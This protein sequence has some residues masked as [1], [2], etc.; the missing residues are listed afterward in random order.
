MAI[1]RHSDTEAQLRWLLLHP[2]IRGKGLGSQ[3]VQEAIDFCREADYK[4]VFLWTV[5]S[6]AAAARIYHDAGFHKTE[7]N[8]HTIWGCVL[9][10]QRYEHVI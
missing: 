2:S 7:E 8:T 4:S 3:L 6:L 1:V 5:S 9:T 10:E